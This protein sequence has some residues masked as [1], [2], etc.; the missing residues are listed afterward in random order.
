M[1]LAWMLMAGTAAQGLASGPARG[2]EGVETSSKEVALEEVPEPARKALLGHAGENRIRELE[3]KVVDGKTL[4]EI[5]LLVDGQETEVV[6]TPEGALVAVKRDDMVALSPADDALWRRSFDVDRK[7]LG[8]DGRNP[9]F[10]LTPGLKIHLSDG[11]ETVVFSVLDET[12]IVDGVETRVVEERETED[13]EL[14]EISRNYFAADRTNGDVYYFGEDVDIYEDGKVVSHDGAW[15]AGVKGVKF[16]LIMPGKPGVGDRFYLEDAPG[17]VERVEI[18]DLD[19]TLET[20]LR[21]FGK[22]VYC[23]EDDVLD[24]GVSHKW[25]APGIGMVGDDEM[26]AIKVEE[27]AS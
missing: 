23:R 3:E 5:E 15:L 10:P 13:G 1:L 25:Y 4:Y 22:V 26:R 24:G 12:K 20:P 7:N 27:P 14:V 8:A 9:Y 17:A 21:S 18:V 6:V 11:S 16:G 19:A 2:S